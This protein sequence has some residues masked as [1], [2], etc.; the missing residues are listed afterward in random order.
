MELV[1]PAADTRKDS[2]STQPPEFEEFLK[3][4]YDF[5]YYGPSQISI[6]MIDMIINSREIP[7]EYRRQQLRHLIIQIY[8]EIALN[9]MQVAFWSILIEKYV[10]DDQTYDIR[11]GLTFS[12][13]M[14]REFLGDNIEYLLGKYSEK[15]HKFREK[16][17]LWTLGKNLLEI[18]TKDIAKE[19]RKLKSARFNPVNY[20]FYVDDIILQYLPYSYPNKKKDNKINLPRIDELNDQAD[21]DHEPLPTLALFDEELF[22]PLPLIKKTSSNGNKNPILLSN[23]GSGCSQF[24]CFD[25]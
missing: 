20:N 22:V 4:N 6:K 16:Y 17:D 23:N 9:E 8:Q 15:E 25:V 21:K 2:F 14:T 18:S 1:P 7:F 11:Q 10:W 13:L 12:A 24:L 3:D 19:Y 5:L